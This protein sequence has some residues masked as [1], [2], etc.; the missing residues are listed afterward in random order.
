MIQIQH[1]KKAY[2]PNHLILN[3]LSFTIKKRGLYAI[4]GKS[5]SGK[6]TLL[7]LIGGMDFSYDG[8]IQV[9]QKELK[10][11]TE[12][13]KD[14]YR[15]HI[16]SFVFQNFVSQED[17]TVY[18]NLCK[19]FDILKI[20]STEKRKRINTVLQRVG[21]LDK[22]NQLFKDLSGGEKKRISLA[23]GLLKDTPILLL[24]E[25]LSSLNFQMR[26]EV[27]KILE[28]ESKTRI[29]IFIT[30]E[31]EEIPSGCT[32]FQLKD[33]KLIVKQTKNNTEDILT[34]FATKR[35]SL[36]LKTKLRFSLQ[37][38]IRNNTFLS[39]IVT[40]FVLSLFSIAFSFQ[41]STSISESL[42]ASFSSYMNSNSMVVKVKDQSYINNELTYVNF[43]SLKSIE[44]SCKDDVLFATEFYLSS[45]D[46]FF[47]TEQKVNLFCNNKT[48]SLPKINLNS[49]LHA[50]T[51]KEE[52]MNEPLLKKDE[53][54]LQ[55]DED[56]LFG[57]Y[58]LLFQQ[59]PISIDDL[60]LQKI[61]TQLQKKK[62]MIQIKADRDIWNYH[63]KDSFRLFKVLLGKNGKVIVSDSLFPNYFVSEILHFKERLPDEEETVPWTL[64]KVPGIAL[65]KDKIGEFVLHFLKTEISELYT[66]EIVHQSGYYI[67]ND[68][69]THNH[70][71]FYKDYKKRISYPQIEKF[72]NKYPEEVKK[73]S[74]SSS[75]YSYTASGYISGFYKPFFFSKYK[76][77]LNNIQDEYHH[78]EQN[79]GAF[80]S[81]AI[82]VDQ[83]VLKGDL[84]SSVNKKS[85][86]FSSYTNE[87]L[88]QGRKPNNLKEIAISSSL[89]IQLFGKTTNALNEKL[90]LLTLDKTIP[91]NSSYENIFLRGEA[92]ITGIYE[93]K[94]NKIYHDPF[95]PLAYLFPYGTLTAE[96]MK[97]TDVVLELDKDLHSKEEYF[98]LLEHFSADLVG[99]FPMSLI[100][101][102]IEHTLKMLSTLFLC[103]SSFCF[104]ASTFLLSLCLYL[105]LNKDRKNIAVL[106]SLGYR[107]Q[108]IA[109]Y[110]FFLCLFLGIISYILSLFFS[111][112]VERILKDTLNTLLNTY[113][114]RIVP[115]LISFVSMLLLITIVFLILLKKI[116][117]ISPK[118]SLRK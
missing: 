84:L 46:D 15:L 18:E 17:E 21:L 68:N 32:I 106:L 29:V 25:P 83:S 98:N 56:R 111:I 108:D 53:I 117:N 114:F 116:K 81:S 47:F 88:I 16:V 109:N 80:Q 113:I 61:N 74:Y 75:V 24:D 110:Y 67:N 41:L 19:V 101:E 55:L 115:F 35:K 22:K 112:I 20:D 5:G 3:D 97:P 79:L 62:I 93:D 104:I 71:V 70:L 107:K 86:L 36:S 77:K 23:R 54:I 42:K 89:A 30:H 40:S 38:L 65:R 7:S 45:L 118:D 37:F 33:G 14:D 82:Q 96:Q 39:I 6:T 27:T 50:T 78:S 57:L 94:E 73:V 52:N 51:L 13:E 49:F 60:S 10:N 95:F 44:Q 43:N 66:F 26:Q 92:I 28:V 85:I 102:E 99:S 58:Q 11:L 64:V 105:I 69:S 8:S 72:R 59:K 103:L 2:L 1:L 87:K 12:K 63:L 100:I 34:P 91:Q 48:L 76:D 9:S 4:L 90:Y 31:A